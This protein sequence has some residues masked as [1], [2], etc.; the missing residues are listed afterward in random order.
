MI[1]EMSDKIY[2]ATGKSLINV[3]LTTLADVDKYLNAAVDALLAMKGRQITNDSVIEYLRSVSDI[4]KPGSPSRFT[5]T[6]A[7]N[8]YASDSWYFQQQFTAQQTAETSATVVAFR[9][10]AEQIGLAFSA[11]QLDQTA[12]NAF[13]LIN[14]YKLMTG[15]RKVFSVDL[16]AAATFRDYP[17]AIVTFPSVVVV[18]PGEEIMVEVEYNQPWLAQQTAS[19]SSTAPVTITALIKLEP[20]VKLIPRASSSYT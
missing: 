9:T 2:R 20:T 14:I 11:V 3:G 5:D 19:A 1:A 6:V 16:R 7:V 18:N 17:F 15:Q 8:N 12:L 13:R 4:G 10:K